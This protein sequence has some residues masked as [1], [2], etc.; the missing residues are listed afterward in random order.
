[1]AV[2]TVTLTAKSYPYGNDNTQRRQRQYGGGIVTAAGPNSLPQV[3]NGAAFVGASPSYVAGGI[4]INFANLEGIKTA[5]PFTLPDWCR[6]FSLSGSGYI[7]QYNPLG[8]AIT[9]L[10]LTSNVIT[11]TAKNNFAAGDI[12]VLSGLTVN[13]ALNGI[14]LTVLAG[15]LSATQFTANFTAGNIGSAAELGFCTPTSYATGKPFQ[16]NLQIFQVPSAGALGSAA[17]LLEL[18]TAALPTAIVGSASVNPDV[19][20]WEADFVR[21]A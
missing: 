20:A 7:Y 21:A 5:P 12:V 18:A 6:L 2:A 8:A 9:N 13:T 17:P 19:I 1:M 3:S 11:I 10:A 14:S 16:G 4:R 15:S